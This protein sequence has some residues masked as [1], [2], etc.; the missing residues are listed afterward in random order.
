MYI[1]Q[2]PI[3]RRPLLVSPKISVNSWCRG[4]PETVQSGY[5]VQL[6]SEQSPKRTSETKINKL[7]IGKLP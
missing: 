7:K 3:C 6:M 2:V 4:G 5:V 1:T